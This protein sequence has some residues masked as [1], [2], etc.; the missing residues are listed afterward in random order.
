MEVITLET[1]AFKKLISSQK[2]DL[3]LIVK[4]SFQECISEL[5]N[6]ET[7]I[8]G[9]EAMKLLQIKSKTTLGGYRK[10]NEIMYSQYG[11]TIVYW[12]E[13]LLNFIKK[14]ANEVK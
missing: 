12:K 8:N 9:E 6:T 7:W 1:E 13:S 11:G 4:E 2:S 10:K 3:K 14:H 5:K